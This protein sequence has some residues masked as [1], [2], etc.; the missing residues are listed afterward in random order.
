MSSPSNFAGRYNAGDFAYG[1]NKTVPSLQVINGPSA[2][3]TATLTLIYASV[4]TNDG[5]VF[6]PLNTNAPIIVGGDSAMET[7]TPSAVSAPTPLV[8]GTS[9][10]TGSFTY[11]HGTGDQVRSGSCGLQEALNLCDSKG[12]GLVVIDAG[13]VKLGGTQAMVEAAVTPANVGIE[14]LRFGATQN[15]ATVTLTNAQILAL[16]TTPV[17][18]LPAPGT[19]S[20]YAITKAVLTN[21]CAGVAYASGGA[22]EIGYGTTVATEALTGTVPSTFMT[23]QT[24]VVAITVAG[25]VTQLAAASLLNEPIYINCGTGNF[26]TGTGTLQVDLEYSLIT[27]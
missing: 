4:A 8:Y 2:T 20:F 18:L 3:G 27:T 1:I 6:S 12:G 15:T 19:N 24:T 16:N 23:G 7:I 17:E 9:T 22:I 13:W 10:L 14:D 26:T 5:V 21:L 11:Q 25:S